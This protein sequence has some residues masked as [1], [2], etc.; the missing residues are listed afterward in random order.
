MTDPAPIVVLLAG[1][2]GAGKS[3]SAAHLLKDALAVEEFVNA[4]V[5][6][7]GISAHRPETVAVT[8]GRV[9]LERLRF[10]AATRHD[11]ALETTLAGRG[12]AQWLKQLRSGGYRSQ[13]IFLSLPSPDLAVARVADRVRQ[14][15]HDVR[16]P[17]IWRRFRSGLRN[18]FSLYM[19]IVDGWQVY[20]NAEITGPR[21][22]ASRAACHEPVIADPKAWR[23]L[24]GETAMI[25]ASTN[26]LPPSER[27]NDIQR[28]ESALRQAI[29]EALHRHKRDGHPVAVWRDGRVVW[30]PPEDIP[31][32]LPEAHRSPGG[33]HTR[34]QGNQGDRV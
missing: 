33:Q 1:P 18:L 6:A 24:G 10:L 4:D 34:S 28:I 5:I 3:T 27:V 16:E 30:T 32:D 13:L 2:N 20:D 8:A 26:E 15:G 14:G 12:H 19:H 7:Q 29:R 23:S 21:L 11:F 22:V 9:M 31:V 25:D 17:I